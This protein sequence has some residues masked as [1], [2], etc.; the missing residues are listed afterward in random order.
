MGIRVEGVKFNSQI[1]K[2]MADLNA[3]MESAVKVITDQANLDLQANLFMSVYGTT[4]GSVYVR[5]GNLKSPANTSASN[6]S[7]NRTYVIRLASDAT[8][9]SD[10]EYGSGASEIDPALLQQLSEASGG[11]GIVFGRSGINYMLPGPF[12]LP[13]TVKARISIE[14]AFNKALGG[15]K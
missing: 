14:S 8:Y 1:D 9:A 13:A 15:W 7:Q 5:T 11:K 12:V 2:F 3:E 10:I 6:L 4:P